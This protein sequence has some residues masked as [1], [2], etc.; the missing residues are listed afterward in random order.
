[1]IITSFEKSL[2]LLLKSGLNINHISKNGY[3]A[4]DYAIR[5]KFDK[6]IIDLLRK[7]GAKTA[8]ELKAEQANPQTPLLRV[9]YGSVYRFPSLPHASVG[10]DNITDTNFSGEHLL[11]R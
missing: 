11:N 5:G 4:L 9:A 1:L 6:K 3:T 8:E 2:K 10:V 7:H